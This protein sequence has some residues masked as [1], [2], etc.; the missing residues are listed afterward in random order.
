MGSGS[1][2]AGGGCSPSACPGGAGSAWG[3]QQGVRAQQH[4]SHQQQPAAT[5]GSPLAP[6]PK[7]APSPGARRNS[8]RGVL[9]QAG[10]EMPSGG[11]SQQSASPT[12]KTAGQRGS[13]MEGN[14]LLG[15]IRAGASFS[16][17]SSSPVLGTQS[18]TEQTGRGG[19]AA[20]PM[21][22]QA[23]TAPVP[24]PGLGLTAWLRFSSLLSVLPLLQRE[25]QRGCGARPRTNPPCPGPGARPA[26]GSSTGG[27]SLT[28]GGNQVLSLSLFIPRG[29]A[30]TGAQ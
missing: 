10:G 14:V 12:N 19:P 5:T 7:A 20:V 25:E 26:A 13:T 15:K 21:H 18:C 1:W 2:Q 3:G 22:S 16:C 29:S 17:P 23:V 28:V 27:G 24:P 6:S 9:G 4:R 11:C 30:R 8:D